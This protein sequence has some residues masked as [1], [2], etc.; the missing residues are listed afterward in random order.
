MVLWLG[1]HM[2]FH[3]IPVLNWR[4]IDVVLPK[5]YNVLGDDVWYVGVFVC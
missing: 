2:L 5:V 4:F 3:G 1:K